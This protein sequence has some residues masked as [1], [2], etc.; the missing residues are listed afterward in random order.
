MSYTPYS[1]GGREGQTN[2]FSLYPVVSD[3]SGYLI[4]LLNGLNWNRLAI[5]TE[6]GLQRQVRSIL[7][8]SLMLL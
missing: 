7:K 3:T 2:H 8:E 6:R 1:S 5:V 4:S